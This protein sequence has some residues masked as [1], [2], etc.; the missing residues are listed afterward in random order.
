MQFC[1]LRSRRFGI[2]YQIAISDPPS[3]YDV[4]V[5]NSNGPDK[6]TQLIMA[7]L[8]GDGCLI[9]VGAHI[10]TVAIPA[11]MCGST[12]IAIEMSGRNCDRLRASAKANG[13]DDLHVVETAA[14]DRDGEARYSGDDAWGQIS[15][16]GDGTATSCLMLDTV[17][18]RYT[19][20][21]TERT[22]VK[23]DVEGHELQVLRGATHLMAVLKPTILFESIDVEGQ[24]QRDAVAI[25]QFLVD[26]DF[27]LYLVRGSV[28]S[29]RQ[30]NDLQEG[31]VCDFLA[32]PAGQENELTRTGFEVR[33]LT[34]VERLAW[35]GEMVD[36][37]E[38]HQRHAAGVFLRWSLE[39]P[40]LV[41]AGTTLVHALLSQ[42]HLHDLEPSLRALL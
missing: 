30:P 39:E 24:A 34:D 4:A 26:R 32:V 1:R 25:R 40:Q 28:L 15:Q 37:E 35:I 16:T 41:R 38:L 23:I 33:P 27:N 8:D 31:V 18:Q 22:V 12:V 11:A 10:G 3:A 13:L 5:A 42:A 6:N 7:L 19:V 20:E 21:P 17:L 14:S 2:A 36:A 29:P 9:D